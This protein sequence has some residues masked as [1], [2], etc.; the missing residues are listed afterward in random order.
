MDNEYRQRYIALKKE[1]DESN[2]TASSIL[3]IYDFKDELAQKSD[4]CA[5]QILVDVYQLLNMRKSAYYLLSLIIDKTDRK[6]LKKLGY[7]QG[8]VNSYGDTF[9]IPKPKTASEKKWEQEQLKKLPTFRYHPNPFKTDVF[10]KDRSVICDSCKKST[11][12]YYNASFYSQQVVDYLCPICIANGTA[13]EKF[14]GSF[15]QDAERENVSDEAKTKELFERTPG[16]I[17]WQG[18]Y[19][20]ACCD[21]YCAFLGDVGTKELEEM[22]IADEVFEAYDEAD[23]YPDDR[24][25]L[26]KG[27]STA[28]YL[29]QCL[30]CQKYHLGVD[31]D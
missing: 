12:I 30:H 4:L 10:Q 1:Y 24:D 19:W 6:Q 7:L 5:K 20:L 28:G 14:F 13:A 9:A 3:A 31:S 16:Y 29:F 25:D 17:S 8:T 18:E 2:G 15:I 27:G 22:S 26:M 23:G 21:D 11:D